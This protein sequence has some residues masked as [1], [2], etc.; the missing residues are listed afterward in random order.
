MRTGGNGTAWARGAGVLVALVALAPARA[1]ASGLDLFGFGMRAPAMAGTGAAS[2]DDYEALHGNPAG[3]AVAPVKRA[4]VGLVVADFD[5][6]L[7]GADAGTDTVRGLVLGGVVPVP[8][9]GWA[10]DR[11]AFGFGTYV[12]TE[13]LNKARAPYPGVPHFALLGSR[14]QV[15]AIQVGL[16][17]RISPRW[18]VGASVVSLAALRGGIHVAADATGRFTAVSE[19]R[20]VT[21][22]AP[23]VG[24]RWDRG[25]LDLGLVVRAPSR[26]DYDV[27]ITNDLA[28]VIG[29]GL[30]ELRIAG[31]AQYD[32]LTVAV[33]AAWRRGPL[34]LAGQLAWQRWSAYPLPSQNPTPATPPQQAPDFHDTAVP[35]LGVEHHATLAGTTLT[36]RAGYAF[37]WSPAG[38][39]RGQQSL[40]DNHRHLAG[41]GL[42]LA[43]AGWPVRLD[44][45][46]QAHFLVDRQHE[47]DPALQP[48]G[49]APAFDRIR[50][51]GRIWVGGLAM[52]LEL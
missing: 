16:G 52:G 22:F 9:G 24:A 31:A 29:L 42:G 5:L 26:S 19:Q 46:V 2:A 18:T 28:D 32:P 50:T 40:L 11:V 47:K 13:T 51:D 14:A 36:T 8:L 49:A 39:Q 21:Q 48:V 20:I 30:P 44:L 7:D 4:T 38:E 43:R 17:V 41:L 27:R 37:L 6:L 1:A 23:I 10:K 33:E 34:L 35:R 15:V 3:L 25:E 45:F 12:P